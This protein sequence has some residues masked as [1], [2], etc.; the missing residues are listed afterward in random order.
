VTDGRPR[1]VIV[2]YGSGNLRSLQRAFERAG[3]EAIRSSDP[4]E[5]GRAERI[6]LPGQGHFG[7]C[8]RA[9]EERQLAGPLR[10]ALEGGVPFIG[11][12]VGMQLLFAGSEE[13]PDTPGFGVL[14]G[15]V[16]RIR[17]ADPLPHVGWNAVSVPE[18]VAGD[19][20]F[21]PL[22]GHR[23]YFYH[24]HSYARPATDEPWV[25]GVSEYGERFASLVSRGSVW[26]AQFHPEKSQEEGIALLG[27][28]GSVAGR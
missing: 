19:P 21:G 24:V 23:P 12:C 20:V 18:T 15:Q 5:V 26:G 3:V 4:E 6:A 11:V 7:A 27:R 16:R 8:M 17:T 28:F 1:V 2:D 9:L 14:P 13:A 10:G 22:A 25:A